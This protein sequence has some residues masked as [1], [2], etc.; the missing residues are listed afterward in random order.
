MI[1]DVMEEVSDLP[2]GIC[3]Y[4]QKRLLDKGR[5]RRVLD[6]AEL[7]GR[8]R[9]KVKKFIAYIHPFDYLRMDFRLCNKTRRA[10]FIEFNIGCNLG[11]H[12][13]IMNAALH[14]GIERHSVVEHVL[15]YSL[16]RQKFR[17]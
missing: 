9:Q 16:S 17:C 5:V 10:Y 4:R 2:S 7:A 3:T 14:Q 12:A 11:S 6:D 1:L 13:A 8:I 15:A